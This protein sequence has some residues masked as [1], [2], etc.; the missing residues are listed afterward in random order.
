M[1][2]NCTCLFIFKTAWLVAGSGADSDLAYLFFLKR[3]KT[4]EREARAWSMMVTKAS[5]SGM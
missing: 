1:G 2:M 4:K 3:I 5:L